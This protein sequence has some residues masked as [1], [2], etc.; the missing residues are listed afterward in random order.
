MSELIPNEEIAKVPNPELRDSLT[1]ITDLARAKGERGGYPTHYFKCGQCKDSGLVV[2]TSGRF[3]VGNPA[4]HSV[5]MV[6]ATPDHPV[7]KRC[8]RCNAKKPE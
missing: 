4:E 5:T 3:D 6:D 1:Q 2:M 7:F 8:P